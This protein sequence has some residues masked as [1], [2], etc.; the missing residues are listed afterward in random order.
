MKSIFFLLSFSFLFL[1]FE[2]HCQT[3]ADD[4]YSR[5]VKLFQ[6]GDNKGAIINL[7]NAL[8]E[9]PADELAYSFRGYIKWQQNDNIGAISDYSK[10]IGINPK[11]P[12][13]Y[14]MRG[15]A[16]S[17]L[18]DVRGALSDYEIAI[19]LNPEYAEAYLSRGLM[20]LYLGQKYS[21]CLDLSKAGELGAIEAYDIIAK[22]CN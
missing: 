10:A 13:Y 12:Y 8:K 5:A 22:F 11:V 9:N 1:A 6:S 17:N 19:S 16:K 4:Y 14:Y 7:N 20:K 21:G 18:K 15:S 2:G 3:V